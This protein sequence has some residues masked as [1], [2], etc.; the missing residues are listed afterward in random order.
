MLSIGDPQIRESW[1]VLFCGEPPKKGYRS[2]GLSGG[3][4]E[5]PDFWT[6]LQQWQAS[7]RRKS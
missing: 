4:V 3:Y 2:V 6:Q 1:R 5:D 7:I